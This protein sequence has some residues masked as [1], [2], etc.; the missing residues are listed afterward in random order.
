MSSLFQFLTSGP[1]PT[2]S[3]ASIELLRTS[4][5][6]EDG[7]VI[8]KTETVPRH[9]DPVVKEQFDAVVKDK[10][11]AAEEEFEESVLAEAL[12]SLIEAFTEAEAVDIDSAPA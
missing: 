12:Y 10:L 4:C 8:I 9:E 5:D 2:A 1:A 11:A 3:T 6:F 7:C